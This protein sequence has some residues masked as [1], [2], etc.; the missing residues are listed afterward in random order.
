VFGSRSPDC[1]RFLPPRPAD[2][3]ATCQ[4]ALIRP[5]TPPR[6][7]DA[8]ASHVAPARGP[9]A[10]DGLGAVSD[11]MPLAGCASK[12]MAAQALSS[13]LRRRRVELRPDDAE[14]PKALPSA[15]T[16]DA[17]RY[18]V[19]RIQK[20]NADSVPNASG[21]VNHLR[22]MRNITQ[23]GHRRCAVKGQRLG[24]SGISVI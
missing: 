10:D 24:N 1:G 9:T 8:S 17:P 4:G 11:G 15:P 7:V 3:P 6:L 18:F 21:F 2:L 5:L 12:A 13:D 19:R 20:S 14:C 22:L 23:P 16:G